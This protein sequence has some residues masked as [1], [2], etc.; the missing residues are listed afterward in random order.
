MLLIRFLLKTNSERQWKVHTLVFFI[1]IVA[2][3]GGL[4]L[5]LGDPPLFL[6]YLRG[7]DF[8]WTLRLWP[9]WLAM[10]GA[11][12]VV[13][14]LWDTWAHAR[15]LPEAI[16][17]D[18]TRIRP[19]Q[20]AGEINIVWLLGV[21]AAVATLDPAKAF[22]FSERIL[23]Q[24]WFAPPYLRE[25]VQLSMVA[26][27]WLTT[28][29][30]LRR[31]NG[32]S[33]AAIGEVACLFI[34]IFITMQM[35]IELLHAR[36]PELRLREPWQFF[37]AAGTLSSVL[38]NAPTYVVYF[39]TAVSLRFDEAALA[40]QHISLLHLPDG[41]NLPESLLAAISCGAVFMGANTY[42]GNG[43]NFMVKAIAEQSGVKMPSFFGY[44]LYSGLILI[45][46]FVGV[47]FL[48]MR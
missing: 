32:F 9:E 33:F 5:P 47:T 14:F 43:P 12:L 3:M 39:E 11:L 23:G 19:L 27:S 24:P 30:A 2:N 18:G 28:R 4:L 21:V 34:G 25:A 16:R 41:R 6:G 20:V 10:N 22:P 13:Y 29:Q 8:F 1:F 46:M 38:D 7:V 37:W 17:L 44:M 31:E 42:I 15:E 35:P 40:A 48:F 45:P 26:L 36:G